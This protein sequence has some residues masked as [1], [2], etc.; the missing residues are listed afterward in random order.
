MPRLASSSVSRPHLPANALASA[1]TT[2][3]EDLRSFAHELGIH[4]W[5]AM[6]KDELVES[7]RQ[8][9]ILE[10]I[11]GTSLMVAHS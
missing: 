2:I 8:R 1:E 4:G 10:Q 11:R 9:W 6:T 5:S 7:L 3:V